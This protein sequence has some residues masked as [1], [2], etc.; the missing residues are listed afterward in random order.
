MWSSDSASQILTILF[1]QDFYW[2]N[3]QFAMKSNEIRRDLPSSPLWE[4][5]Y[6]L[7]FFGPYKRVSK[8]TEYTAG[9]HVS[10]WILTG[11]RRLLFC[12]HTLSS[13]YPPLSP[14]AVRR[15]RS[16]GQL[17][18]VS[19]HPWTEYRCSDGVRDGCTENRNIT[20]CNSRCVTQHPNRIRAVIV[21]CVIWWMSHKH[22]VLATSDLW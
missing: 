2:W 11:W 21:N 9:W 19:L 8:Q 13:T 15:F 3:F 14:L 22:T 10:N 5:Y 6:S 1:S 4:Y 17:S 18:L 12:L 20:G 7:W 16:S